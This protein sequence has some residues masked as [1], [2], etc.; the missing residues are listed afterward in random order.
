MLGGELMKKL[1]SLI[2]VPALILVS[3]VPT[4]GAQSD[5]KELE[6]A[7]GVVKNLITIEDSYTNFTYSTWEGDMASDKGSKMWSLNW[8]QPKYTKSIYAVVDSNGLLRNFN[9][10]EDGNYSQSF[11]S[12]S[13]KEGE[14][15][16]LSFL[17]KVLPKE[18]NDIR[19][20]TYY[21]YGNVKTYNFDLYINDV[22]VDFIHM[23]VGINSDSHQVIEYSS[24]NLGYL[25]KSTFPA[26][27]KIISLDKGKESY[28]ANIG[29]ELAYRIHND[30]DK[31][32]AK[33]FLSYTIPTQNWG[34]D[35]LTGKLIEFNDYSIY[36]EGEGGAGD[37]GG[38]GDSDSLS[39]IEENAVSNVEG[40]I[41]Q[42]EAANILKKSLPSLSNLGKLDY[43]SLS[44]DIFAEQYVWYLS[45]EKGGGSIDA[46]TG[47]LIN[48]SIYTD[49]SNKTKRTSYESAKLAA[50]KIIATLSPEKNKNLKYNEF[51]SNYSD[52][53][54]GYYLTYTRQEGNLPVVDNNITVT[55]TKDE[56]KVVSYYTNWNKDI[57]FPEIGKII[58][59]KEAFDIFA[60]KS[61]FD[62]T[63]ILIEDSPRLA[64][65]FTDNISYQ[66]NPS[67][68]ELIDY[69]G[70]IFRD[71]KIDG[72][73]DIKGKWYENVVNILLENSYYLEGENFAGNNAISQ[74]EFFRYLYS[75]DYN[76]MDQEELYWML[77]QN[78]II[79]SD[80]INPD[81]LLLRQDA[82]KF[83]IRYLGLEKAGQHYQIYRNVFKDYIKPEYRG[84][85]A[86]S[87]SLGIIQGNSS[88]R[89]FPTK[90]TTR[91]EAAVM[92]YRIINAS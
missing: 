28:L 3:T 84:Y 49:Y 72:Y 9:R 29:T 46:R 67:N 81:G 51:A 41:S 52:N 26:P 57:K 27:E 5:S 89:F 12:L 75:K 77:E 63:Y 78:G 39:P 55:V 14:K 43:V 59:N 86:L 22:K 60:K 53:F 91:A 42:E 65:A 4:Y 1:L 23:T 79:E 21:G 20:S 17:K 38:I 83:A 35:A 87:Q 10:Y 19:Y 50:E 18:F 45:Y 7:I 54:D 90:S 47:E 33:T 71:N 62:L 69:T 76:Y 66:I 16:A 34:I 2:I 15:I 61:S 74:K 24:D 44:K 6:S 64:Y 73:K 70:K 56:G 11:G 92:I 58:S 25:N 31:Q 37:L 40:L 85:T 48:F 13:K 68:G 8:N 88:K 80:E 82:A 32:I 30:Y 36:P